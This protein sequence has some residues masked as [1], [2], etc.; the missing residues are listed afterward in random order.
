MKCT[1][2]CVGLVRQSDCL[3][4]WPVLAGPVQSEIKP[5]WPAVRTARSQC[6]RAV[7]PATSA[8]CLPPAKRATQE[9]E[10]PGLR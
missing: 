9:R 7:S 3:A 5:R 4:G 2:R 10:S 6:A 8:R 1:W